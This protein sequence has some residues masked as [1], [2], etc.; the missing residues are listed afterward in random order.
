MAAE[1]EKVKAAEEAERRAAAQKKRTLEADADDSESDDDQDEDMNDL[2]DG[3]GEMLMNRPTKR[4]NKNLE[5]DDSDMFSFD[6]FI[7]GQETRHISFFKTA[8][9][10]TS[11]RYRMFP[12]YE[13]HKS[14]GE[15]GQ[16]IDANRW[17]QSAE[18]ANQLDHNQHGTIH[19]R[20]K[21]EKPQ[22]VGASSIVLYMGLN[23]IGHK[24]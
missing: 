24:Y 3:G 5:N 17:R 15:F 11:Q 4:S 10:L 14:V 6:I 8:D 22:Q 12:F 20:Q 19:K 7:R 16:N 2:Q 13:K 9:S 1:Q 18:E 21:V 23:G